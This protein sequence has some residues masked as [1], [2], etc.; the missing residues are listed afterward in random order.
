MANTKIKE[1][2]FFILIIILIILQSFIEVKVFFFI[3]WLLLS[4]YCLFTQNLSYRFRGISEKIKTVVIFVFIYYIFYLLLGL[5]VGF[6]NSPYSLKLT[7]ILKNII[8]LLGIKLMQEYVRTSILTFSKSTISYFF[9][10]ML[11]AFLPL[12][13]NNW[14]QNFSSLESSLEYSMSIVIPQIVES[15]LLTYLSLNG[16]FLLNCSYTLTNNLALILLPVFP[17]VDWFAQT[18]SRYVLALLLFLFVSYEHV[19][20]VSRDSKRKIRKNTP[21]KSIPII[22]AILIIIGFV[23]GFFPYRPI[24][25]VSNSMVPTFSRGDIC[26]VKQIK[27]EQIYSIKPDDI[28]QYSLNKQMIIHRV[29]SIDKKNFEVNFITKGDNNDTHDLLEVSEEQVIGKVTYVIPYLGYPSVW[30]HEILESTR[31]Q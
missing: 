2:I 28:I 20:K 25:V 11:F 1:I 18:T 13:K 31:N 29:I 4:L 7:E 22:F 8:F 17:D 12:V 16:G 5:I 9:I 23:A 21:I 10:T 14:L 19:V 24:A 27:K 30:F 3:S 6:Q 15:S 26:I